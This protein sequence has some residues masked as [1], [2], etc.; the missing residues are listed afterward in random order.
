[1]RILLVEDDLI[2]GQGLQKGLQG[3]GFT[4]DWLQDGVQA[5][6]ALAVEQF[7]AVVLDWGLPR[8]SGFTLLSKMRQQGWRTP[9]LMLTARDAV[10]DRIKGLDAG[11]DDYLLKPFVLGEVQARLRA[12]IRRA[13]GET[14]SLM[15]C[16][17]LCFDTVA[18]KA[19]LAERELQLAGKEAAILELLLQ[20]Q[21]RPVSRERIETM[22][23]GWGEEVDS[24][25]I[26]VHI[27]HLRKKLG[28]GWIKTLRGI[29]YMLITNKQV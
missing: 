8:Q 28:E 25:A 19:I 7:D 6:L 23:Y 21:G 17:E 22:L 3:A 20:N 14:Q 16:G 5:E 27:H 26:E 2:L 15:R 11:A 24:N 10:E 29:G 9:V 4:V 18:R 1:M 12:L 13:S